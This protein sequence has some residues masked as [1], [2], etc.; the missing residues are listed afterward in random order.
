M[1]SPS[2][3]THLTASD[4]PAARASESAAGAFAPHDELAQRQWLLTDGLGGYATGNGLDL[5]RR[6]YDCWLAVLGSENRRVRLVAGVDERVIDRNGEH[7]LSSTHWGAMQ[8]PSIP[9]L[10]R[11]FSVDPLPRWTMRIGQTVVER[12]LA[13]PRGRAAVLARWRNLGAR[14]IRMSIRPLLA[15]EDADALL[16][17]RALDLGTVARDGAFGFAMPASVGTLWLTLAGNASFRPEPCWY[18]EYHLAVDAARGYDARTDRWSPGVIELELDPDQACIAAFKSG[19]PLPEPANLFAEVRQ[20]RQQRRAWAERATSGLAQRL[21][22]GVDDF[23][24]RAPGGRLGVLAGFPW[25]GEWGRDVFLALPGLSLSV[26]EP[27]RCAE[28]LRAARPF[29]QRGLLPNIYGIAPADSHYGS[30]DAA[31][32]FALCVQRWQDAGAG[33]EVVR[34]EF[35]PTLRAIAEAYQA[36]TDLGLRVDAE[37][38]LFAGSREHNATW[39]DAQTS[40]GPVTPRE[41]QPVEIVALWCSLLQH[42]GELFGGAWQKRAQAVGKAFV[43]R[44]WRADAGCLFD[45]W[46]DGRGDPAIRPNMVLAAA[47]PRSPL[48][49]EQRAAIVT[50]SARELVTPRGLR[51]LAAGDAA[52]LGRYEGGPEQRDAAYHQGTV[53]PWLAG[54]HVEAALRAAK[55][56][57]LPAVRVAQLAWLQGFAPEIDRTGIDHLSEVFDGDAPQRPGG[58]F[59]Q[60]WNS[61]E[62]LRAVQLCTTDRVGG[63]A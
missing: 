38:L 33:I 2:T 14:P 21:R 15:G 9:D 7:E 6:R 24:Y 1:L 17:E 13:M 61:G 36:G 35:G 4:L 39:M 42:L 31:L 53:W 11:T 16:R 8:N 20:A 12:T 34:K 62:L 54:F 48:T 37:G 23:F 55:P 19:A 50:V 46:N 60:A 40:R 25:F 41:G 22:R 47:L 59:A 43:T 18:R 30:A 58:T 29:L 51:T 45:R 63:G 10:G 49:R 44:F 27:E 26:D 28:V 3:A 57:E 32:W 52:Y 56:A 5:P